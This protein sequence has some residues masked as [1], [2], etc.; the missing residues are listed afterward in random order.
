MENKNQPGQE[1][2]QIPEYSVPLESDDKTDKTASAQN[3][4]KQPEEDVNRL[5]KE[6][7][8]LAEEEEEEKKVNYRLIRKLHRL[9][10]VL[11]WSRGEY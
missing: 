10:R 9:R 3:E 4:C 1:E 6:N 11:R 2:L 7:K 5:L 8:K